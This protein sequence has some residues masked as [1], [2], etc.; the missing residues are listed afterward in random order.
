MCSVAPTRPSPV[1]Q[2]QCPAAIG[3]FCL[4]PCRHPDGVVACLSSRSTNVTRCLKG[5]MSSSWHPPPGH[6]E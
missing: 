1:T 4:V 3:E 2:E 5:V 6:V